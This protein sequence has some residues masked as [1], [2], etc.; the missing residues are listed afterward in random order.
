M[1]SARPS[2]VV[3]NEALG[4][5]SEMDS[6]PAGR[7]PAY[8]V[9]TQFRSSSQRTAWMT[10][11]G[12]PDSCD[13]EIS[14]MSVSPPG[15][16]VVTVMPAVRPASAG[17]GAARTGTAVAATP[18][19][20]RV[21]RRALRMTAPGRAAVLGRLVDA[22]RHGQVR[23]NLLPNISVYEPDACGEGGRAVVAEVASLE[24]TPA[25]A[26]RSVDTLGGEAFAELYREHFGPLSGYATALTGDPAVAVEV[27]QEAFTRLLARWR[28]VR[29][30]RAWLFFVATNL[31]RDPSPSLTRDR[32]LSER[33]AARFARAVPA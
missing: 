23:P 25:A 3:R 26:R 30:P 2:I 9:V 12:P 16:F 14:S 29:D 6:A 10:R 4:S 27:A 7:S 22:R 8:G 11:R 20:P 15:S 28:R 24:L 1:L 13:P 18:A 33:A 17:A 31:T 19:R 5:E 21:G 32:D